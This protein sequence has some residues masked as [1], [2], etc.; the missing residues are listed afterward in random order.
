MLNALGRK[1]EYYDMP[2]VRRMVG[3]A[4]AD[5]YCCSSL[6]VAAVADREERCVPVEE[7]ERRDEG[8][9]AG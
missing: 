9:K 1:L 4:A 6:L 3:S 5:D 2:A 7:G 8:V